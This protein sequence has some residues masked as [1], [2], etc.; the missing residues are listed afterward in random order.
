MA[1][2]KGSKNNINLVGRYIYFRM[3]KK[4]LIAI[5]LTYLTPYKNY[6]VI[7]Q[8]G[9][10]YVTIITDNRHV[11]DTLIKGSAHLGGKT[12][13]HVRQPNAGELCNG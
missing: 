1:R 11:I 4:Q 2:A 12:N 3:T 9:N 8:I 5:T 7:E 10:G 13:W 6:K